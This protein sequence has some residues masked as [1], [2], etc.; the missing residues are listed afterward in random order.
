[1]ED[2]QLAPWRAHAELA[3]RDH[4]DPELR[5][6]ARRLCHS[7]RRV[8]IGQCDRREADGARASGD[9]GW[10]AFTIGVRRVAVEINVRRRTPRARSRPVATAGTARAIPGRT[11]PRTRGRA[12]GRRPAKN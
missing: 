9:L 7:V 5:P 8:V 4:A 3:A 6:L 1:R 11:A 2:V 12:T 10:L